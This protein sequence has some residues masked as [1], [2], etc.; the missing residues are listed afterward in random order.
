[1]PQFRGGRHVHPKTVGLAHLVGSGPP[2]KPCAPPAQAKAQVARVA[3]NVVVAFSP[4]SC[5][6]EALRLGL[7]VVVGLGGSAERVQE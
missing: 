1:M 4:R 2:P 3:H 7:S 5:A 6:E